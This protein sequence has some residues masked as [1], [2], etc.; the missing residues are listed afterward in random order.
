MIAKFPPILVMTGTRAIDM[1]PAIVTN[2]ALL[3]A[4]VRSALI[5][6]EAMGHCYLHQPDLPESRKAYAATVAHFREYL[7]QPSCAFAG[8]LTARFQRLV[9]ML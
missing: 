6:A 2:S 8:R 4:G 1:T 5:V 3:R 7:G 9:T